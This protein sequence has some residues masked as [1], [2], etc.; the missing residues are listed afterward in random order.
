MAELLNDVN[1]LHIKIGHPSEVIT[2]TMGK[3]MSFK[4]TNIF[5]TFED[6]ALEKAKSL[7]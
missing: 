7:C 3:A 4:V 2:Q 6:R 1:E 5:K